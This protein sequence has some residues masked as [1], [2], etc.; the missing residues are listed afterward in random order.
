MIFRSDSALVDLT[1]SKAKILHVGS[2]GTHK[3]M[4]ELQSD[5]KSK[6]CK[7]LNSARNLGIHTNLELITLSKA[8]M[9]QGVLPL[10]PFLDSVIINE[11]EIALLCGEDPNPVSVD[12]QS[13]WDLIKKQAT[14]VLNMG[15][16]KFVAVHTPKGV[17]A[18]TRNDF[19][20]QP[21]VS[22]SPEKIINTTGAGMQL[23]LEF[24]MR[25]EEHTSELQSH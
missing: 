10:L 18:V 14:R 23:Q 7:F 13:N 11:I 3:I 22:L 25:S 4:D 9:Q 2:P 5:G 1:K 15:V 8:Q 19:F 6:W 12:S 16:N 21:S 17:L 24:F 20:I